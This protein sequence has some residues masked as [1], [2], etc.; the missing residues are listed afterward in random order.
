MTGTAFTRRIAENE[1]GNVALVFS[2]ALPVFVAVTGLAID[3]AS[4]YNQ[5]SSMQAVADSTALAVA[6]ELHL[7]TEKPTTLEEA[8]RDKAEAM[9]AEKGLAGLKHTTG[10]TVD[11]KEGVA[12]VE[13]VMH[14]NSFLPAEIWGESPIRVTA[15]A[16][17]Y[18][19]L[20]LCV[21][22]LDGNA[23][24]TVALDKSAQMEAPECAVQSNSI[25]PL[26]LSA[27][28]GSSLTAQ[29]SCSAGGF[30]GNDDDDEG[31]FEPDPETDCPVLEDPLALRDEPTV[32]GCDY[33]KSHFNKGTVSISPGTY[34]GGIK[35]TGKTTVTAEPGVYIIT[36]GDLRVSNNSSL[37]GEDVSFF[38]TDDAVINFKDKALIEL[39]APK[40]GPMAGILFFE[41]RTA[42]PNRNFEISSDA[43]R[44]LLGTI[45]LS[46]GV[47][48]GG[49]KGRIADASDYTIII[50]RRI[51]V[52]G[53]QLII[54]ADYAG[55]DVPVPDGLGPKSRKVRLSH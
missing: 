44:K 10:V 28:R 50:A 23:D 2:L 9:L 38:F 18:G 35:I 7:F 53:S 4:F 32:G 31:A 1:G 21:L 17:T 47:F 43:A 16:H 40:D 54:N 29:F 49:G 45:Y 39:S 34:C 55:S 20:R 13:I 19:D 26:G 11:T 8:G 36:G 48:K 3:S 37:Q 24:H 41:T 42:P 5:Q 52:E 22:G 30:N 51:D 27:S 15:D 33:H 14:A 46:Q 6:K 25:S 12:E